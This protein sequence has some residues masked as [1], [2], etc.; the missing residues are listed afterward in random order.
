MASNEEVISTLNN[1]IETCRDGQN[2]FQ[3]AADGV[4]N[5]ELKQLFQ[6]YSRQRAGFVGELQGEV[7]R[8]GGDPE[9]S[10]SVAATLHRGW[11]DI[12]AA[13][14]GDDD[15]AVVSEAE[16]GEDSAVSNYRAALGVDLPANVRSMVER[17]FADVKEA[18]D[19]VRNL[20]RASGAGA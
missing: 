7:R 4:K 9:D 11:I 12:K 6:Q 13:V 19:R 18:H 5:A 8:L 15:K 20:E 17:Q 14:T 1:L 2:G 3:T 10:G 16:R